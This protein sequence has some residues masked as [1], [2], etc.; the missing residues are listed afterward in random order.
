MLRRYFNMSIEMGRLPSMVGREVFRSRV[1]CRPAS[2]E[3]YVVYVLDIERCVERLRWIDQELIV[4]VIFQE[5]TQE[6]TARL[7]NLP[8]ISVE[9]RLPQVLDLLTE[10]FIK[11]GLMKWPELRRGNSPAVADVLDEEIS[12][13]AAADEEIG[14]RATLQAGE[15]DES[16]MPVE[17]FLSTPLLSQIPRNLHVRLR[18]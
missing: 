4:R 7:L 10:K 3:N 13:S 16:E 11:A 2:F 12:I 6:E 14:D 17:I 8:V 5:H 9:R 18:I 15:A 1:R